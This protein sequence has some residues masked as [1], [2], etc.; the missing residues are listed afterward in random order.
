MIYPTHRCKECTQ[1]RVYVAGD[2]CEECCANMKVSMAT[3][4][5]FEVAPISLD[6]L[7]HNE[8]CGHWDPSGCGGSYP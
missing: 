4:T 3:V 1:L 2:T 7:Q 6:D 8:L 5:G